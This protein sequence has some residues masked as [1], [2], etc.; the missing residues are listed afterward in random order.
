MHGQRPQHQHRTAAA[1]EDHIGAAFGGVLDNALQQRIQVQCGALLGTLGTAGQFQAL[2]HQRLHRGQVTDQALA[3]GLVADVLQAQAQ[4]R[5]RR[6][7]VMGDRRQHLRAFG[8]VPLQ[9]VL[10]GVEGF[11]GALHFARPA[12]GNGSRCRSSPRSSAAAA[13]S[14][15]GA[16]A[17]RATM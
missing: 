15:S 6:L 12:Q 9:A 3:Q 13:S 5:Q 8:Q 10:H 4:P 7:Q 17:M 11:G 2:A 14:C 1:F 16:L